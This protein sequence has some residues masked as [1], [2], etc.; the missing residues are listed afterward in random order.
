MFQIQNPLPGS[1][2]PFEEHKVPSRRGKPENVPFLILSCSAV[3]GGIVSVRDHT[4][5]ENPRFSA[6]HTSL[7]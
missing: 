3:K 6:P 7:L 5:A 1:T 4:G 2:F